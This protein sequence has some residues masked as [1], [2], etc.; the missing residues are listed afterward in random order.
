MGW[1][2]CSTHGA[3]YNPRVPATRAG[4]PPS[5]YPGALVLPVSDTDNSSTAAILG[6][7]ADDT[8]QPPER[9]FEDSLHDRWYTATET[10]D[11]GFIDEI[12]SSLTDVMPRRRARVGLGAGA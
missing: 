11:Y 4:I 8:G 7:I 12:V 3:L 1:S 10:H 6:L 2:G 5:L 9:I